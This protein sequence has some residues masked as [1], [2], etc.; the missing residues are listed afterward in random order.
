M[1]VA[2]AS[3]ELGID[4][5]HVDLVC[6]LGLRGLWRLCCSGSAA[7]GTASASI[8]KGILFPMTRDEL[9]QCA[10]A[11]WAV[12]RGALDRVLLP[13]AP[14]DIL[15]Q[16]I[17]ATAASAEIT[18]AE[19]WDLVH[20]AYPYRHLCREDFEAVLD[21]L[22]EGVSTRRGRGT[23]LIHWDRVHGRIL[24]R[25][26]ARLAAITSG[27]AIPDTADYAVIEEPAETFVGTVNEDF[28]VESLAGDIFLLGN[29]SWRIRRVES[30]RVRVED[31]HGA[32]PTIPFWLGEAPA[33]TAELSEAVA[34]L[35]EE[36]CVRVA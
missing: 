21:I 30:G 18:E 31:A 11:V 19:L 9:V 23:A 4:I 6:H 13:M 22:A 27:G 3:L 25:R 15:A 10:A 12:R 16:Q 8:P 33:R 14:L 24:A 17:V 35:R 29:R 26:G 2:T 1:V 28:A 5:G 36:V 32:P 34:E 7:P 20:G